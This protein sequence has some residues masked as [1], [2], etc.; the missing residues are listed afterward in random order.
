ME[1]VD[2]KKRS[3]I[4][5]VMIALGQTIAGCSEPWILKALGDWNTFFLI[6]ASPVALVFITPLYL[7]MILTN[8]LTM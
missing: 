4:A 7:N 6:N 1:Y 2:V 3:L 5:N 8:I